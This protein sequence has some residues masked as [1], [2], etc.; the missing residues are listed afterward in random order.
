M[1][2]NIKYGVFE[3]G[4]NKRGEIGNL[5]KI[6]QPE[7]AIITNVS[8]AHLENF[9]SINDIAK[10]KS[11]IIGNILKGGNIILNKDSDF[12]SFLS[13]QDK[14]NGINVISLVLKKIRYFLL[15]IKRLGTITD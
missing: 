12:F 2:R 11:E 10:A 8:E 13:N 3:I 6:I 7:T 15:N 9:N 14:K 4:M 1:K 5:S